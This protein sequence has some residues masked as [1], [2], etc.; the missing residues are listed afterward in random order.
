MA[1][2]NEESIFQDNDDSKGSNFKVVVRVR[3]LNSREQSKKAETCVEIINKQAIQ[4]TK[5]KSQASASE[6]P[7]SSAGPTTHNFN[8]DRVFDPDSTQQAV[9]TTA[10]KP[11]V[12]SVLQGYNGSV[13]AYGQTGTGKTFTI[14]GA[15][16]G[17]HRGVIPR[18][19][20]HVFDHIQ[21]APEDS[22][23][24]VRV[25]YLQIYNEKISDL[26]NPGSDN[27][28]IRERGGN[29]PYVE[30]LS[31][32]VAKSAQDVY[33][34]LA[35]GRHQRT[36]NSTSM[37][38]VSSR[39]HAVFTLI[40]EHSCERQEGEGQVVTIGQLRLVDLAGSERFEASSNQTHQ[41]ETQNIN[42]SLSAFGK[43]VLA[44]TS[45]SKM[46]TPYRDSKLTRILQSSLG[47]NC[48][49]TMITAISPAATSHQES[50][51]S[52]KFGNRAQRVK[53]H[54][55]CNEDKDE[56][57]LL[58]SYK[59][60]IEQLRAK[61]ASAAEADAM[62]RQRLEQASMQAHQEKHVIVNELAKQQAAAERA[63]AEKMKLE[64]QLSAMQASL[65]QGGQPIE[66]TEEFQQA[67]LKE[68]ERLEQ[69]HLSQSAAVEAERKRLEQERQELAREKREWE[70]QL[71]RLKSASIS[72]HLTTSSS[73]IATSPGKLPR[74][75]STSRMLNPPPAD[76]RT[77][78][79]S[80]LAPRRR[81][82]FG[83]ASKQSS[84]TP[85][86]LNSTPRPPSNPR[87]S[88]R[89]SSRR[90][91]PTTPPAEDDA[92]AL[93]AQASS[94]SFT[95]RPPVSRANWG[96]PQDTQL[97]AS[98]VAQQDTDAYG[99]SPRLFSSSDD[100]DHEDQDLKPGSVLEHRGYVPITGADFD[101]SDEEMYDAQQAPAHSTPLFQRRSHVVRERP[102]LRRSSISGGSEPSISQASTAPSTG[103]AGPAIAEARALY[104]QQ[105]Q[106][107]DLDI[108][109]AEAHV[110][111]PLDQDERSQLDEYARQLMDPVSGIAVSTKRI[112]LQTYHNVFSGTDAAGWFMA[113]MEGIADLAAAQMVG[114]QL[115][116]VGIINCV[117]PP[118]SSQPTAFVVADSALYTFRRRAG[119][120]DDLPT[121]RPQSAARPPSA[122]A[123]SASRQQRTASA[124]STRSSMSVMSTDG[125]EDHNFD[126]EQD[127]DFAGAPLLHAAAARGDVA[128]VKGLLASE[129]FVDE[130]DLQGRSPLMYAV[131]TN[132]AR[133]L[134][135]LLQ[136][137]ADMNLQ[138]DAGNTALLW[139]V[140]R[141]CREAAKTLIK[142]GADL[143]LTDHHRRS[144]LHWACKTKRADML[145]L[146]LKATFKAM[147][148]RCD[149][150]GLT[151]LHWAV[152]ANRKEHV[153][154][155]LQHQAD[156]TMTDLEG[157]HCL[158]Y[159]ITNPDLSCM[160]CI[161]QHAPDL[162]NKP[163]SRGQYPLHLACN[164]TDIKA[165]LTLLQVAGICIDVMDNRGT[166]PLHWAAA[167]NSIGVCQ[168]LLQHG[169]RAEIQD[170]QGRTALE[171]ANEKNHVQCAM[172]LGQSLASA[173]GSWQRAAS[174]ALSTAQDRSSMDQVADAAMQAHLKASHYRAHSK[175]DGL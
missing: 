131:L 22:Q 77:A 172:V 78:S 96:R 142:E 33:A 58:S 52:L 18:C 68:K 111:A 151:P 86:S 136:A 113:N 16:E 135:A 125:T 167:S 41:K 37:N 101:S 161:L 115:I 147:I 122:R 132:K 69:E 102:S 89:S 112:R 146:L 155:L 54:A 107:A 63:R 12:E 162:T 108:A 71:Q 72:D 66:E 76:R 98:R 1:S 156:A 150:Q 114:Q 123:T 42:T 67:V 70:E 126:R 55:V 83:V 158:H 175:A 49:T 57:A 116:D 129:G 46:H 2:H 119:V 120:V 80:S 39:S 32:H 6:R 134:K 38:R 23:Y 154:V 34:L 26:L 144:V 124:M 20:S 25:S 62:E 24:L 85:T 36:T 141:G 19:V 15:L 170:R 87:T 103:Q 99:Q 145:K 79:A 173:V 127:G 84:P 152:A 90:Y 128:S 75:A 148:D 168:V 139:A 159:A 40:V 8:Y 64:E 163:D 43:V 92:A 21:A 61:L 65:L 35:K 104:L 97:S 3:P 109:E 138:D 45:K 149:A 164:K 88:S 48:L 91:T 94:R 160:Q 9:Y 143:E 169:A 53:N 165:A 17:E 4:I 121:R 118:T 105:K 153:I 50:V 171:Y 117:R 81:T 174:H 133:V 29:D 60:E 140:C 28:K 93:Q 44:L 130:L 95:P 7:A 59:S 30:G 31:E 10:V 137:G 106:Q 74:S 110:H 166:T 47:G 157:R 82:K 27:L 5:P 56:Q 11:V 100:S 13:I 51:A 73:P 14:E